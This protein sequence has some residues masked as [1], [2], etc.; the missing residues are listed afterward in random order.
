MIPSRTASHSSLSLLGDCGYKWLLQRERDEVAPIPS[1]AQ[2]G[3]RGF[4][5]FI[6]EFE[7]YK[8]GLGELPDFDELFVREIENEELKSGLDREQFTVSGRR[9]KAHPNKEDLDVWRNELGPTMVAQY[10]AYDWGDWKIAT[11]L[12]PD[13]SGKTVG[14]EYHVRLDDPAW[15]QHVDQIRVDSLGNVMVV[16]GKT[17]ARA[18][19][20]GQLDKYGCGLRLWGLK[21]VNYGAYYDARKGELIGPR[22]LTWNEAMFRYYLSE[23]DKLHTA[24]IRLPVLGDHC[25]WCQVRSA[26]EFAPKK[27]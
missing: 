2:V 10:E 20:E 4:H 27:A 3:G 19:E 8:L 25:N 12:P 16:D 17:W 21:H 22:F 24:E 11:D 9:S 6:D 23:G 13:V 14:I 18:H 15:Q 26:C 5:Q 1:L 7:M